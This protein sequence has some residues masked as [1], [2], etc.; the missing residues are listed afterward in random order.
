V[1]EVFL[2]SGGID[3]SA[4]AW[5][6]RSGHLLF[7]NYGQVAASGERRAATRLADALD[8]ELTVLELDCRKIGTGLLANSEAAREAPSPEWWPYRNQL[9][10]TLAATWG[11]SRGCERIVLGVVREDEQFRDGTSQ[12]VRLI[13][14]LVV[15]QEGSMRVEAPAS[16]LNSLD[17]LRQSGLPRELL[18]ITH[19]CDV[20]EFHCGECPSC[21][22]RLRILAEF[23]AS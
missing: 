2:L 14:A 16:E 23:D 18:A 6:K 21:K 15:Y 5:S 20:A 11:L 12:F 13:D 7:V 17:L 8:Q 22:G 10:I 19:S 4:L 9:L 1:N 3:S